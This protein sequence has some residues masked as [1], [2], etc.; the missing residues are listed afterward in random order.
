LV[1]EFQPSVADVPKDRRFA[2]LVAKF[3][4]KAATNSSNTLCRREQAPYLSRNITIRN[5]GDGSCG[6]MVPGNYILNQTAPPTFFRFV[7]WNCID[8]T[9]PNKTNKATFVNN[10]L[11]L[12][13]NTS[14]CCIAKFNVTRQNSSR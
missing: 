5:P 11:V 9:T 7:A 8:V 2:F 1:A 6:A 10:T 14:V 12:R 3:K 13:P 4:G